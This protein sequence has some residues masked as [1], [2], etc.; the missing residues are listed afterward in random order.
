MYSTLTI[1]NTIYRLVAPR[2]A[3]GNGTRMLF[4]MSRAWLSA[5]QHSMSFSFVAK[6]KFSSFAIS[7]CCTSKYVGLKGGHRCYC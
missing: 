6:S 2:S 5:N 1:L 7:W 4:R 3:P